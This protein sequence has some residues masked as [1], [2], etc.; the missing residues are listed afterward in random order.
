M[1][2]FPLAHI[3]WSIADNAD[4]AACD[5]FFIGTFGAETVFEMLVSPETAHMGLDREERLM[6]IG[7]TMIIPIAPAGAG[8][9]PDSP[10]GNMLRRCA[11]A[12]RWLGVSLRVADLSEAD[13][14]FRARGFQLHYDPGMESHYFLISRR[15]ALGMRIEIMTGEL[16]NDPRLRDGWNP[17]RW[18]NEHPLGIEGLQAIGL[19]APDLAS[20]RALF[21]QRLDLPELGERYLAQENADAAVFWLGD[22]AIEAMVPRDAQSPLAAHLRDIQGIRSLTFKV[23]DATAAAEWLGQ[24]GL[25]LIGDVA[26]RFAIMPEQAQGR[27]IWFTGNA[28]AG[29][30]PMGSLMRQPASLSG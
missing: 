14:Y 30:P 19:S 1:A 23:R 26:D 3:S 10:L 7:D 20:A 21:H 18:A 12:H 2:A 8:A 16:P 9:S 27:L 15:Q 24:R 5:R 25:N 11:G 6:V 4:R 13:G 29:Y 22:T 17:G 28:V